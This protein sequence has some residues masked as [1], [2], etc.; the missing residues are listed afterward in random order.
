MRTLGLYIH[1]PFCIKKCYYCDFNSY[2][3]MMELQEGYVDSL[4]K[5]IDL[6]KKQFGEIMIKTIFIGGGTPTCLDEGNLQKL[7][8]ACIKKFYVSGKCEITIES[9]PGTLSENKLK[10]LK[11]TGINRLSIGLQS[12]HDEQLIRLGRIHTR[13]EFLKNYSN[14]RKLGFDNIN[15]DLMFSLP[16]QTLTTWQETLLN[17]IKLQPEHISCYSLK[18]EENTKFYRE[19]HHGNLIIPDE[20]TDREMYHGAVEMMQENQY[21]HYE[22]SNFAKKGFVCRH[23]LIYWKGG[24]YIGLGAGAHSYL[25]G[26]RYS[27]IY[28]PKEYMKQIQDGLLPKVEKVTLDEKD[29]M[30]EFMFLGLRL[31]EGVNSKEFYH[32]FNTDIQSIFGNQINKFI[33]MGLME[34][35][36][37]QYKLTPR[38]LDISNQ[39]FM[40]F[41]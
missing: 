36:N 2:S 19:Y 4:I 26:E 8:D 7:L 32:I 10:A 16:E 20:D 5:E 15:I 22:I 34:Q 3:N 33:K 37:E 9:N 40:E 18:I 6:Y 31:I 23:N 21:Q 14:A 25:N 39:I 29:R 27:S 11:N 28:N 35:Q 30:A 38:G 13:E 1:I 24:E 17:I 41:I 12:W